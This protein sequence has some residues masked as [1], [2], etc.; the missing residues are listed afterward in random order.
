MWLNLFGTWKLYGTVEAK[1]FRW[2]RVQQ[3]SSHMRPLGRSHDSS[4]EESWRIERERAW[5]KKKQNK[6]SSLFTTGVYQQFAESSGTEAEL[7]T[8]MDTWYWVATDLSVRTEQNTKTCMVNCTSF[9]PLRILEQTLNYVLVSSRNG[10][11]EVPVYL[12]KAK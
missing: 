2:K 11:L 5:C 9:E 10:N 7:T 4:Q 6:G 1:D 3:W 12:L 8:V